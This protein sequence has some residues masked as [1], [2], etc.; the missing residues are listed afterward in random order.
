MS[1]FDHLKIYRSYEI[2]SLEL[3]SCEMNSEE[4]LESFEIQKVN[5]LKK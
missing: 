2:R 1:K 4:Y 3:R 5:Q